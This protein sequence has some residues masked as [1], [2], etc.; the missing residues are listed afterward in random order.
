MFLYIVSF[1]GVRVGVG[2][3]EDASGLPFLSSLSGA[4]SSTEQSKQV[5]ERLD[6]GRLPADKKTT[7]ATCG[8]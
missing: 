2:G 1:L 6:G 4:F 7:A 3:K 8:Q 5:G